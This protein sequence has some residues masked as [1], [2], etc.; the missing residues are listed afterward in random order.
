MKCLVTG[1]LGML[2]QDTVRELT[3]R[4]HT[5]LAADRFGQGGAQSAYLPLDITDRAAVEKTMESLRPEAVLHLAAYTQVDAAED[6]E[7]RE[8]VRRVNAL[9]T[10]YLAEAAGRAGAKLMYLSTDYVFDGTGTRPWRPEDPPR[11]PLNFYGQTKLEGE[12]AVAGALEKFYIVRTAWVFGLHGKNFV[13]TM[14]GLGKTRDSVR[15]VN[16][17]IGTPT[18]TKDL[19][20]L[21][22][23]MIETEKYGIYHATN[24]E[25]REGEY[26]SWADLAEETFRAAGMDTEVR[27]VKAAE[28]GLSRAK[29]PCNSRLDKSKLKAAGFSPLPDWKDALRRYLKEREEAGRIPEPTAG[30]KE[31][32]HGVPV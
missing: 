13:E 26:I 25:S 20:R 6:P 8:E 23:D 28:Y 18:Y 2:G 11:A 32:S 15:V 5:A 4:G 9:G 29:R 22:A 16:D 21:L 3:A 10:R 14:I 31:D 19:A 12:R 1:A 24:S 7:N 27:R 30:G 17:Q